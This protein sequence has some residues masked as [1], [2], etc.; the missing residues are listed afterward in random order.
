MP[1]KETSP[2]RAE[3]ANAGV[4]LKK[5][6]VGASSHLTEH[7]CFQINV[8]ICFLTKISELGWVWWPTTLM[9]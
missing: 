1:A 4:T 7:L 8:S 5:E 2:L 3:V 6:T 9:S